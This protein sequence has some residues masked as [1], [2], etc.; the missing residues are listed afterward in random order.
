MAASAPPKFPA[1]D[2]RP[3]GVS[4]NRFSPHDGPWLNARLASARECLTVRLPPQ[5]R[6]AAPNSA[7]NFRPPIRSVA[8]GAAVQY[9]WQVANPAY[10]GLVEPPMSEV[11]RILSAIEQGDPR[12][13]ELLLPLVY[14]E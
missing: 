6:K 12:A 2:A 4:G 7:N 10:S 5:K 14:D 1:R 9:D 13:A 8:R 3:S 11:T